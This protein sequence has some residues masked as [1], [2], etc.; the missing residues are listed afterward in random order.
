MLPEENFHIFY[1]WH[2]AQLARCQVPEENI[3]ILFLAADSLP[4]WHAA[5]RK[6]SVGWHVAQLARC[7][8]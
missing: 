8:Q 2:I 7:Q 5:R 3:P 6:F 4:S 1:C